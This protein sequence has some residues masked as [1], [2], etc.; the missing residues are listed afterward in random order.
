MTNPRVA[1]LIGSLRKN[2]YSSQVAKAIVD[3][4]PGLSFETVEIGH[5][6]FYNQDLETATPPQ[7]WVDFRNT[8]R[9]MD[10]VLFITP[11]YNRSYPPALKNAIDIGSRP[12]G[13][14]VFEGKPAAIV[15]QSPGAMGAVN[16]NIAMR[17]VLVSQNMLMLAK[18][19]TY[20]GNTRT[21]FVDGQVAEGTQKFIAS[22]GRAFTAWIERVGVKERAAASV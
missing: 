9:A 1:V 21:L 10:A 18:P 3:L 19:E 6:S 15:S 8:I 17:Q 13:K 20:I 2:S 4:T 16:A 7:P 5:L 14:S 22:F 11:E 12:F